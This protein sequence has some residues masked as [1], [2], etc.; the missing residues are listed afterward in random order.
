MYRMDPEKKLIIVDLD[1]TL[2]DD[3]HR[4][5]LLK[6]PENRRWNEYF[7][8]CHLD[9]PNYP[10]IQLLRNLWSACG[11][12]V[13]ILSGRSDT[14]RQQTEEWLNRHNVPYDLLQMREAEDRTQ[15]DKLK[16]GWAE[17]WKDKV[18]FVLEDRQRVVDAWR[19]AGYT[20]L[21]VA[22]GKF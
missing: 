13:Y 3:T 17:Q 6:D 10:I 4:A 12:D 19:E 21:Q 9:E 1:G 16:L 7:S 22:P 5:H 2:A 15:D 14:V 18:L 11:Y 20:C 8:L